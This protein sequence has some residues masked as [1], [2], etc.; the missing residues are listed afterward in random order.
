MSDA[1]TE[2][3]SRVV[4]AV[5]A[6]L[7]VDI[8]PRKRVASELG[9]SP[10]TAYW[11]AQRTADDQPPSVRRALL[12]VVPCAGL[13]NS[14]ACALNL[15]DLDFARG[16]ISV[17]DAKTE[18]GVRKVDMS[19]WL[20]EELLPYRASRLDDPPDAPAFP[21]RTGHRRDKDNVNK[22]VI[23]PAVQA[24]N[25]LREARNE[26]ALP[27]GVTPHTLRRTYITLML[28]ASS[29]VPYVQAQVGHED[30]TTTLNIYAQVLRR[31]DRGRHGQA[32]DALM[33]GAIPSGNG[34]ITPG[35]VG[36]TTGSGHR[37]PRTPNL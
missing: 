24:A 11:L 28:E 6:G 21:T 13:R 7:D 23:V 25:K 26:P 12:A 5:K 37:K 34:S 17:R 1:A 16:T 32:F 30:A 31:R 22:R 4:L 19:P 10:G 33:A 9:V 8:S 27:S 3:A 29:P 35:M 36:D 2:I 20:R 14:E 15:E 18:A